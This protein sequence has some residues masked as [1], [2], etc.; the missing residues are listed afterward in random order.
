MPMLPLPILDVCTLTI[1]W[2]NVTR[3][4]APAVEFVA[5]TRNIAP[6]QMIMMLQLM[7]HARSHAA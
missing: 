4:A 6:I 7:L 1:G 3:G 5:E 2:A